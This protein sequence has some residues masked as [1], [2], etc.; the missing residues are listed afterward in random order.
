M[1]GIQTPGLEASSEDDDEGNKED[2]EASPWAHGLGA[3]AVTTWSVAG[4]LIV[5]GL[6]VR[7][8]FLVAVFIFVGGGRPCVWVT[9][10]FCTIGVGFRAIV[11]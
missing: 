7:A 2:D 4:R 6:L 11:G 9:G 5:R 8:T 10:A 1:V 3:L